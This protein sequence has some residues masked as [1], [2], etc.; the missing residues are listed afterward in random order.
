MTQTQSRPKAKITR[1]K[2][3]NLLALSDEKGTIRAAA[4]DQRGSLKRAIAKAK[5]VLT[6][7]L[8]ALAQRRP[9]QTH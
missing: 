3:E 5:L 4:M 1:G 8:L 2:Y 7:E 9:G 6:D